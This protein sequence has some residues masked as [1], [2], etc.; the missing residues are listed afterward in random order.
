MRFTWSKELVAVWL[1]ICGFMYPPALNAGDSS[2]E[3]TT[4]FARRADALRKV[5]ELDATYQK[6]RDQLYFG[7]GGIIAAYDTLNE[8]TL[9]WSA[10]WKRIYAFIDASSNLSSYDA[11]RKVAELLV[12]QSEALS[13]ISGLRER[14]GRAITAA[15][16]LLKA[17]P[18][19]SYAIEG[20]EDAY[21]ALVASVDRLDATLARLDQESKAEAE[22]LAN[23][24]PQIG[25]A[26]EQK[27]KAFLLARNINNLD[28]AITSVEAMFLS[29]QLLAP[30]ERRVRERYLNFMKTY[31][32]G[33][34][35]RLDLELAELRDACRS[36]EVDINAQPV[37]QDYKVT[38]IQRVRSTCAD[39]DG[40]VAFLHSSEVS[41]PKLVASAHERRRQKAQAACQTTTPQA[42]NCAMFPWLA[43]A[44]KE[45]IEAMPE[46]QLRNLEL[47]WDVLEQDVKGVAP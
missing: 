29:E 37:S 20:Y 39:A 11:Q 9:A 21:G 38:A 15:R 14:S 32:A 8:K 30:L 10:E 4:S 5:R 19:V 36:T 6:A 35:F 31:L 18:R 26:L 23:A 16:E 42:L 45:E 33:R 12:A 7:S 44:T 2:T 27:L 34:V 25:H 28:Q 3:A 22:R 43:Q 24:G 17:A 13:A 46:A 40:K 1:S 41:L 47:A